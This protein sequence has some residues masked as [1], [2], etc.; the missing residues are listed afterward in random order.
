MLISGAGIAGPAL[1]YRLSRYGF[2]VTVVEKS[3]A[4]RGGGYAIDIR[5]TA[6]DV[7]DRVGTCSRVCGSRMSPPRKCRSSTPT[8][9]SSPRYAPKP[10]PGA[11]RARIWKFLCF[12]P[13]EQPI[14]RYPTPAARRDL[15]AARFPERTWHI[16]RPIDAMRSADD[17]FF[18]TVS[19]IHMPAWSKGRVALVGDAT[20][21]ASFL[22]DQ[23]S[24]LPH[25]PRLQPLLGRRIH[26]GRRA[27]RPCQPQR[28]LR[29]LRAHGPP[30][31]EQNQAIATEGGTGLIPGTQAMLA[32][33]NQAL[34]D[35]A[36]LTDD[37]YRAIHS[38]LTLPNHAHWA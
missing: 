33:R 26:S 30:L 10:S 6:L 22:T 29:R 31:I 24:S 14:D 7:V 34:R 17:L 37:K 12:Q 5:G 11:W 4:I 8:A 21:A 23:G 18:D 36:A 15:I 38:A 9:T 28:G 25:R 2:E 20:C 32:T 13:D 19:Q 1:A 16:P 35:P 27:G 3:P